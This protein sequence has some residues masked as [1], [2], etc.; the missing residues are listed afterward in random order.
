MAKL[1]I[2]SPEVIAGLAKRKKASAGVDL[3]A[4]LARQLDTAKIAYDRQF[5]FSADHGWR[6]D[7]HLRHYKVLLE[8]DGGIHQKPKLKMN[9]RGVPYMT[10]SGH[11]SATGIIEG[12]KRQNEAQLLGF[13][14]FRFDT[15]SVLNGEAMFVVFR[16]I[17]IGANK[18]IKGARSNHG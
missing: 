10:K 8:C 14:M 16:A 15:D 13:R 2:N 5:K 3:E 17:G 11:T 9:K 12:M 1:T 4:D 7:F 6:A 18:G